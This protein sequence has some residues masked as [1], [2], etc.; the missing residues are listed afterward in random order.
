MY[1]VGHVEPEVKSFVKILQSDS[2]KNKH[3]K[4]LLTT[5]LV[6]HNKTFCFTI[7]HV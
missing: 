1:F 2:I 6:Q 3:K 7:A 5:I 4:T